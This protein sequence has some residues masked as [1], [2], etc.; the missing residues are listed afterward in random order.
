M[1]SR[2]EER[3]S[4]NDRGEADARGR[5]AEAGRR[6]C[7]ARCVSAFSQWRFESAVPNENVVNK[8]FI[9]PLEIIPGA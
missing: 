6:A 8:R 4:V 3:A 9:L 2:S 1:D 7:E 5:A